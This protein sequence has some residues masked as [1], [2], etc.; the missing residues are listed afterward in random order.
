MR[1]WRVDLLARRR[2]RQVRTISDAHVAIGICPLP[3]RHRRRPEGRTRRKAE[4]TGRDTE[5]HCWHQSTPPRP[6]PSGGLVRRLGPAGEDRGAYWRPAPL[7]AMAALRLILWLSGPASVLPVFHGAP[8]SAGD[9]GCRG[10]APRGRCHLWPSEVSSRYAREKRCCRSV[11]YTWALAWWW[12]LGCVP[13][14]ATAWSA[15]RSTKCAQGVLEAK[16]VQ[17]DDITHDPLRKNAR[18]LNL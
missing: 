10:A 11:Q 8:T 13:E 17:M 16:H 3:R 12:M 9:V 18:R 14:C 2:Q 7:A 6:K 5:V 4:R 15:N 1:V